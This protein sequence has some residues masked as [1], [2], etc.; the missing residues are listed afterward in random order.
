MKSFFNINLYYKETLIYLIFFWG[1]ITFL[2]TSG[3]QSSAIIYYIFLIIFVS[4]IKPELLIVQYVFFLPFSSLIG[5]KHNILG[6][7]GIDEVSYLGMFL[8]IYFFNKLNKSKVSTYQ[9]YSISLIVFFITNTFYYMFKDSILGNSSY[10]IAYVFK[11]LFVEVT[12]Y[13]P[14]VFL[15]NRIYSYKIRELISAGI[16]F[17]V[18][19]LFVSQVFSETL[20]SYG[21]DRVTKEFELFSFVRFQGLYGGGG[22][23]NSLGGFYVVVIGFVLANFDYRNRIN[24]SE[25]V[26]LIFSVLGLLLTASRT[27][28]IALI[29]VLVIFLFK[30]LRNRISFLMSLFFIIF[31]FAFSNLIIDQTSRF[32]TQNMQYTLNEESGAGRVAIWEHY[33]SFIVNHPTTYFFGNI[34]NINIDK[35]PHN[36]FIKVL[37]KSGFFFF[38]WFLLIVINLFRMTNKYEFK[39]GYFYFYYFIPVIIVWNFINIPWLGTFFLIFLALTPHSAFRKTVVD[40]NEKKNKRINYH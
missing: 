18:L 5:T 8:Y 27:A 30:N 11:Y 19:F 13:F 40:L 33:A 4:F 7:V 2:I 3:N 6:I 15:I 22:D 24:L 39:K 37:Y 17:S 36:I 14:L 29:V 10:N 26:V 1:G 34:V 16:F 9:K 28:I 20:F 38:L 12:R 35:S 21:F 31:F 32:N 23:V 25:L